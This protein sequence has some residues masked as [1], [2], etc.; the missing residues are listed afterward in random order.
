MSTTNL[1]YFQPLHSHPAGCDPPRLLSIKTLWL[2]SYIIIHF[3]CHFIG[4]YDYGKLKLQKQ[5]KKKH[6]NGLWTVL[7]SAFIY[8][9]KEWKKIERS[10]L[11]VNCVWRRGEWRRGWNVV[12][13]N[14]KDMMH[15]Y[16]RYYNEAW[17]FLHDKIER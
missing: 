4:V 5:I 15:T 3:L 11:K 7:F 13:R 10:H 16:I 8:L 17:F 1:K 6:N 9:M 2:M 14:A 12:N